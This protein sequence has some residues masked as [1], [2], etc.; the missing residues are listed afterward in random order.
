VLRGLSP[1][2][3]WRRKLPDSA[4]VGEAPTVIPCQGPRRGPKSTAMADA[5]LSYCNRC[6]REVEALRP[7]PG[8]VWLKRGWLAGLVLLA[9]LM[10]IIMSEITLLLPMAMMFA[11]AGGP[12]MAL[13]AQRSTC[14]DCGAQIGARVST[15]APP[16]G[17]AS[18]H[19]KPG[20]SQ[21]R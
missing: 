21:T 18:P 12:V 9:G 14:R 6:A 7:W 20:S 11:V 3:A 19:A 16:L 10:P 17:S 8:Y 4:H 13:S 15:P 1:V 5:E 2:L